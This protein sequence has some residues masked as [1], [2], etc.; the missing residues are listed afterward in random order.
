MYKSTAKGQSLASRL[1]GIWS[2]RRVLLILVKRDLRV[3]YANSILGYLWTVIEPLADALIYFMIFAIILSRPDAGNSPYFLYLISGLFPWQWFN[4]SVTESARALTTEAALVKSTRLP[5][6]LWVIRVVIAKGIEYL[7]SM[8][9]FILF[10]VYYMIIG[11]THLHLGVLWYPVGLLLQFLLTVGM[12][13]VL[14]TISVLITDLLPLV[15]IAMRV[16]FYLT[17]II[18]VTSLTSIPLWLRI[19]FYLNPMTGILEFY[20][21]GIFT[22]LEGKYGPVGAMMPMNTTAIIFSLVI[23]CITL[24]AGFA[25]F[26]RLERTVLKEI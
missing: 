11:V 12:G 5:R 7:L 21:A 20:R 13:L 10:V 3:R 15:R 6:E 25:V 19:I 16:L 26:R 14:S 22:D 17:P 4:H 1:A 8:P 18:F 2:E 24:T 23:I 9:V